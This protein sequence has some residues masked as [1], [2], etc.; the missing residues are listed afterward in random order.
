M[1]SV[2]ELMEAVDPARK[3]IAG[4][5]RRMAI[6]LTAKVLWQLTGYKID[7]QTETFSAEP[8]TGIGISARPP[9]A[10]KPE[11][12]VLMVGD[13][14]N[15]TIIAVRDEQTRAKVAGALGVDETML[16]N[17]K[18]VVHVKANETVE[19]RKP[20]GVA[21]A[22]ATKADVTALANFVQGLFVGGS[23]S[24][25]VPPGTVPQPSGTTVLKGQ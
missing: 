19:V 11:A 18:A 16:F 25:V 6:T 5:V 17:S 12:I 20:G 7:G 14:K 15:P 1:K 23:G 21:V 10:S 22:L 3:R 4:A 2:S 13:A 8:F 9:T 24:A